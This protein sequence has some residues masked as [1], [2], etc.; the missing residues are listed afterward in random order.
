MAYICLCVHVTVV[1]KII[2]FNFILAK[3]I[4]I[5]S[6]KIHNHYIFFIGIFIEQ[7]P[8]NKSSLLLQNILQNMQRL[9]L[10]TMNIKTENIYKSY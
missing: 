10:F 9:H 7:V 6:Q 2:W 8:S 5:K 1:Y 3:Q 4:L